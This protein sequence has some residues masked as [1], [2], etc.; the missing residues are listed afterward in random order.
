MQ[1]VGDDRE[2]G[3]FLAAVLGGARGKG[4]ADLAVQGSL[5]PQATSLIEE[6][7]DLRRDTAKPRSAADNDRS[8]SSS[9]VATGAA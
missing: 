5:R 6:A 3:R 1:E 9:I 2:Q 4:P 8:A 7:G